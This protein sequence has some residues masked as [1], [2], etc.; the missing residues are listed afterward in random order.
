MTTE[1]GYATGKI[2][3]LEI[4]CADPAAAARFYGDVFGWR[5]RE[6]GD[7][8]L[9][10]DDAVG[11]V[12]GTWV[13]GPPPSA[14]PGI[15]I[16][17]MVGE[18]GP[19]LDRVRAGG[20]SI[21][22]D[23]DPG[24]SEVYAYMHDPYGNVIGVYQQPGLAETEAA[25]AGA[26]AGAGTGP[27]NP[28]PEHL[29]TV[30]ARLAVSDGLAALDFYARAFAA[31]EI[32]ERF[33]APDGTLIHTELQIGDA[34]V[35]VTE[36]EGYRALLATH[37]PDVDAAWE[38]AVAAGATVVFPLAD[39]FY[40]ERGGRLED[41]FGQQWMLSARTEILSREEMLARAPRA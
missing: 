31:E 37:W 19:V 18:I 5:V 12:S 21:L 20:G 32:Y 7:G 17:V 4:P 24:A 25:A 40:G 22:R 1:P 10:F 23:V 16:H 34:V 39:Q 11:Q 3:Y 36:D 33:C 29:T 15:V 6:R 9:A 28:V 14:E 41:P 26:D 35:M 27:V 2:C 8:S 13:T 38:R 30:T